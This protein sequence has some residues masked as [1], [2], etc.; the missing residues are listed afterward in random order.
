M[1]LKFLEISKASKAGGEGVKL[2][3][4]GKNKDKPQAISVSDI[5]LLQPF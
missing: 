3:T 5:V 2:D 1:G 4:I